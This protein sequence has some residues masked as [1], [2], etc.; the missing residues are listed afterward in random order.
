MSKH[1]TIDRPKRK[2]LGDRTPLSFRGERVLTTEWAADAF[3]APVKNLQDNFANNAS[4]FEAGKHYYRVEGA[5]LRALKNRPDF[6]GS[7]GK[8]ARGLLLWTERG[9]ARHAK[10]LDTDMAWEIFEE[11]EDTYFRVKAGRGRAVVPDFSDP[12]AAARAWADEYEARQ[13]AERTKAEIGSR[14]EATAM[15]TASQLAKRN[16]ALEI[17]AD[18]SRQYASVKRLEKVFKGR[19]FDWR[20]LKRA[21]LELGLPPK[22][23]DDANYGE[24]NVYHADVWQK[25]YGLFVPDGEMA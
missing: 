1:L 6:I 3:N 22:K 12:V 17:R 25:V 16:K 2:P 4:R 9:I 14:R 21:A 13:I 8:N 18:R 11:L 5:D 24:V 7:V 15:N 23:I 19:T 20:P 10:I